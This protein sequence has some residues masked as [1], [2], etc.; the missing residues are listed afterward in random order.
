MASVRRFSGP[1]ARGSSSSSATVTVSAISETRWAKLAA[2]ISEL[3]RLD[4]GGGAGW[5]DDDP[6]DTKLGLLQFGFAVGLQSRPAFVG[7]DR[8][9]QVGLAGFEFG[10]DSLELRQGLFEAQGSDFVRARHSASHS[11]ANLVST[12]CVGNRRG[13]LRGRTFQRC[14]NSNR[15]ADQ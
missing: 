1:S 4:A 6:F 7:V 10:D 9:F 15:L 11:R 5:S 8:L 2:D 12:P 13:A 14:D 3:G